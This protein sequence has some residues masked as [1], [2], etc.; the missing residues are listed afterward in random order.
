[1]KKPTTTVFVVRA[2]AALAACFGIGAAQADI[3]GFGGLNGWMYNQT[4]TGSPADLTGDT[5]QITSLGVDQA[6]SVFF[7]TQQPISQFVATF[8]YRAAN[9]SVFGCDYG[10]TF[11]L[12]RDADGPSA[13]GSTGGGFGYTGIDN[14][15]AVSLGLRSNSSGFSTGGFLAGGAPSVSPV[16]LVAGNDIDVTLSYNGAILTRT[17]L[18]TV[19]GASSTRNF[20][21]GDIASTIGGNTAY[22]GFTASTTTGACSGDA[23]NQF[24]SDFRFSAVPEPSML[25]AILLAAATMM[26]RR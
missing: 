7:N 10:A 17:L 8:T 11:T 18:D 15:V 26:R 2:A 24:I 1:M 5:L 21:V 9:A 20:I 6:R 14:S 3:I 25:S 19:T 23:A 22:V 12:Q 13:I 16:T 4:D